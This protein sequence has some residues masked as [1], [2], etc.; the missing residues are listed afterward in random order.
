[1]GAL[2]LAAVVAANL[3][4]AHFGPAAVVPVSFVLVGF[5]MTARDRL[6]DRWSGRGLT[7][8][9]G[10]LVALGGLLSYLLNADAQRIAVA[11]TVAFVVSESVNA[12]VYAPMLRRRVPWLARV[13][14]GNMPNA[15]TDSALFIGLAFGWM[16]G[17]MLLQAAVKIGGGLVWSLA[18]RP[19]AVACAST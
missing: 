17:L 2:Y 13:N 12:L 1:V 14:L 3:T 11:S 6:H 4:I 18:L 10:A 5:V 8:R 16:P 15:V 9:M 19:K 7:W